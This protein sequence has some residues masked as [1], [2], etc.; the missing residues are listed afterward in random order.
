MTELLCGK[1]ADLS[2][3]GVEDNLRD[4]GFD[5]RPTKDGRLQVTGDYDL[6]RRFMDYVA[7]DFDDS[8][9]LAAAEASGS[10]DETV[11]VRG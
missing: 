7:D 6:W 11:E 5:V 4:F 3:N 2:D 10:G 8:D 1:A 9:P